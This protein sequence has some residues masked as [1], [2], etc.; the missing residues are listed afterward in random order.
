MSSSTLKI[1]GCI[2]MLIDHI[3]FAFFPNLPILRIIGRL[4]FPIFAFQISI[5][6]E[7]TS[8]KKKYITR[9]L[10]FALA[11]QLPFD[12]FRHSIGLDTISL[13]IGFTFFLSL[14]CISL[15]D[16]L[17]KKNVL[18][19]LIALISILAT[20]YIVDVDYSIFGI[21]LVLIFYLID[22]NKNFM[23]LLIFSTI[24]IFI[25][26]LYLNPA[27]IEFYALISLVLIIFYN[28]KK[29]INL[30][31]AFYIFYPLH[32]LLLFLIKIII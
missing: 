28:E 24:S 17:K 11:S 30:K 13:N 19:T 7:K 27:I 6:Y 8:N 32:M 20:A 10:I 9:M 18:L 23:R 25:Y 21:L 1:L 12:L 31:Y 2:F 16:N 22:I 4:A 26:F 29:G 15:I 3:G 5:G 14:I